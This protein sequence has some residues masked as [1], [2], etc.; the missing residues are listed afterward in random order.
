VAPVGA[1]AL[2]QL[3]LEHRRRHVPGPLDRD[4][5]LEL[6]GVH[7]RL[8][9]AE[10][11]RDAALV[12][13]GQERPDGADRVGHRVGLAGRL[14]HREGRL[15][16]ETA[17]R[18]IELVAAGEDDPGHR[19]Q[20][21]RD[22]R[23]EARH[24]DVRP[25]AGHYHERA[26]AQVVEEVLDAHRGHGHVAD[27]AVEPVGGAVRRPGAERGGHVAHRREGELRTLGQHGH[28]LALEA[29]G[30][31][32]AHLVE[33]L[34]RHSVGDHPEQRAAAPLERLTRYAGG[35]D[36]RARV[37]AGH[38]HEHRRVEQLGQAGVHLEVE[39]GRG[40]GEVGALADHDVAAALELPERRHHALLDLVE[41]AARDRRLPLVVGERVHLVVGRLEAVAAPDQLDLRV[42]LAPGRHD[43]PVEAD[44]LDPRREGLHEA[45]RHDGL[46]AV[47][48]ERGDVDAAAQLGG[49]PFCDQAQSVNSGGS[50]PCSWM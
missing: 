36:D 2:D 16:H 46:P 43:R 19:R 50:L 13:G 17:Q 15:G 1:G 11:A 35:L 40:A 4:V 42:G 30:Q 34:R 44:L 14:E 22:R 5:A 25:V 26:V 31:L 7:M 27:L 10:R 12:V 47:G 39:R 48:L 21:R 37:R 24:D 45:Q 9:Q 32:R 33:Q 28:G 6:R 29:A 20:L 38:H 41:D 49:C 23:H 18:G 8:E 3:V